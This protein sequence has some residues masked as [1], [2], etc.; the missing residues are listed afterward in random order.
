MQESEKTP[1]AAAT[2]TTIALATS[3]KP[4]FAGKK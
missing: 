2:T 1:I 4:T 3:V